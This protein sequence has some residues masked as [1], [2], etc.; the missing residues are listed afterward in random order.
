MGLYPPV[1]S[2]LNIAQFLDEVP[3]REHTENEWL[4]AYARVLQCVAE[5]SRGCKWV[6]TYPRPVVCTADLVE[7]FMMVTEVKHEARD[8]ARCWGKPPDSCP[9]QPPVQ[10]FAQVM[11]LLDSMAVWVPLQQAFD[12]L[13]YPP[14]KP[15]NHRSCHY[16]V[17]V[18]WIWKSPCPRP[19]WQCMIMTAYSPEGAVFCS[20]AGSWSMTCRTTTPNG[21]NLGVHL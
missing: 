12:E 1:P 17:R 19:R 20:K 5:V 11:A 13:I 9:T 8:I 3:N 10:E 6:N 18:S 21:C 4:L 15:R 7:A 16:V 14:Y 2:L